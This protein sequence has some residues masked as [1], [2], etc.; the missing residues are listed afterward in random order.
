M[1][2]DAAMDVFSTALVRRMGSVSATDTDTGFTE[3]MPRGLVI[4]RHKGLS[5]SSKNRAK[6]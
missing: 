5:N 2:G 4:S 6:G 1:G 3:E